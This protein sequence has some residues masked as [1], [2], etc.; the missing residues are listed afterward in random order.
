MYKRPT[1]GITIHVSVRFKGS[2]LRLFPWSLKAYFCLRDLILMCASSLRSTILS[3][4]TTWFTLFSGVTYS[5]CKEPQRRCTAALQIPG[6]DLRA[7]LRAERWTGRHCK[8]LVPLVI[9]NMMNKKRST[10]CHVACLCQ[11]VMRYITGKE[12]HI[13]LLGIPN[14]TYSSHRTVGGKLYSKGVANCPG[15]DGCAQ[16]LLLDQ[17]HST[18]L[19]SQ[20]AKLGLHN[21]TLTPALRCWLGAVLVR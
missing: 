6:G 5:A 9:V 2:P 20:M 14:S 21:P 15:T 7:L 19:G 16:C 11:L 17:P 12:Q 3:H 10:S 8:K 4:S 13:G 1:F 18:L